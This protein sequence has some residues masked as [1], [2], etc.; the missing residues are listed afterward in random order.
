MPA[1]HTGD[2]T[3][4]LPLFIEKLRQAIFL[5]AILALGFAG[6]SPCHAGTLYSNLGPGDTFIINQEYDTNFDFM[7]TTFVTTGGGSLGNL[8]T[9]LFSLDSPVDLRL[10]TD[11]GGQPGA[12]LESWSA[13]VPGFP[14]LLMTLP[15]DQHP[16]L[17]ANTQYWFVIALTNAQ[18]DKLAWYQ[19]NQGVAGGIFAGNSLNGFLEFVPDSPAPAIELN[20]TSSTP[21]PEPASGV[22]VGTLLLI[23]SPRRRTM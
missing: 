16:L 14:G 8:R 5:N 2:D 3:R 21:V 7:A 12:L 19:N 17:S 9:S 11:S 22:L 4:R 23:A 6:A 18:K 13:T 10:Y 15:S 1:Q 20:S